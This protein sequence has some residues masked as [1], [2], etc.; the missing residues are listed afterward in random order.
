MKHLIYFVSVQFHNIIVLLYF[1]MLINNQQ[2]FI[3]LQFAGTLLSLYIIT[4]YRFIQISLCTLLIVTIEVS[5]HIA[6]NDMSHYTA[7]NYE[8]NH[9]AA[10]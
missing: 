7:V 4:S 9:T 6:N 1:I 2:I 5:N 8:S 3:P 10:N